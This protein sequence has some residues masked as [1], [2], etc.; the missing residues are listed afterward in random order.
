MHGSF[1][2]QLFGPPQLTRD[3]AA[4]RRF[5]SRKALVLFA[6][7]VV[8]NT[9][10]PRSQLAALFWPE[11]AE[12]RGRGNLRRVLH[13]LAMLLPNCLLVERH[14]VQFNRA[15]AILVDVYAFAELVSQGTSTALEAAVALYRGAFLDGVFL[16]DCPD[17]EAWLLQQRDTWQQ[18]VI[19]ALEKVAEQ[20]RAQHAFPA[21][22]EALE[23]VV[24]LDPWHEEAHRTIMHLL[25]AS[26]ARDAALAHYQGYVQRLRDELGATPADE[27]RALFDH[28]SRGGATDSPLIPRH[29]IP[30]PPTSLLGRTA[31]LAQVVRF[32]TQPTC[33]LLTLTGPGGTGKTHLA[34]VALAEVLPRFANGA[35][36]V[37]LALLTAPALV[38]PTIARV[39]GVPQ[40]ANTAPDQNLATWLRDKQLLLCLD[41]FE[42]LLEAAPLVSTLLTTCPHIKVLVTSRT[43]L[44]LRGEQLF[45]LEPL[46]LPDVERLQIQR[47]DRVTTLLESPAAALFVARAANVVPVFTLTEA[48]TRVVAEICVRLDGLPL[49]LELA[50]PLVQ[51]FSLDA[52]L[53]QLDQQLGVLAVGKRDHPARHTGMH[54]TIEWS[55]T[56]LDS[57]TQ[58]LFALLGVFVGG[59]TLADAEAIWSDDQSPSTR[60]PYAVAA[61]LTRLLNHSLIQQRPDA[62]GG[63]RFSMLETIR[64]YAQEQ[65]VALGIADTVRQQHFAL[66]Q[67]LARDARPHMLHQG[68][69]AWI[70]RLADE[71]HNLRAALTWAYGHGAIADLLQMAT[72]LRLFWLY[73]GHQREGRRWLE[74]GIAR[75]AAADVPLAIQ[76]Y[77]LHAAGMLAT[78]DADFAHAQASFERSLAVFRMLGSGADIAYVQYDLGNALIMQGEYAR[79]EQLLTEAMERARASNDVHKYHHAVARLGACAAL[80][81]D[82]AKAIELSHTGIGWIRQQGDAQAIALGLAF[83]G[84]AYIQTRDTLAAEA[85]YRESLELLQT[86]RGRLFLSFPLL[87]M[88]HLSLEHGVPQRATTLLGAIAAVHDLLGISLVPAVLPWHAQ[89]LARIHTETSPDDLDDAWAYGRQFTPEQAIA[90]ALAKS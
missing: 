21:A 45:P 46:A 38:A 31:E 55:Y 86:V 81:G 47:T 66:Y 52:L 68:Q 64:A 75:A 76:G 62:K 70:A 48:H 4:I 67:T 22:I 18:R 79:A 8:R 39:L 61:G 82:G 33:R 49:A 5:E 83:L 69:S 78:W 23:R 9:P 15:A 27:T 72:A 37:D 71:Q 54:T 3:G 57:P 65:L 13:N 41:N 1:R 50:A 90:Y 32:L 24:E 74:E 51:L 43:A 77:A 88:A 7:L 56:L 63:V 42:H 40:R 44:S 6:Y 89:L 29:A 19:A 87:G 16:D 17:A 30:M 28:I 14:T 85:C 20:H 12:T 2:I 53:A 73:H 60:P 35:W 10:V 80:R 25:Q 36:F 34:L 58:R 59:W 11:Q 84:Q 26:G